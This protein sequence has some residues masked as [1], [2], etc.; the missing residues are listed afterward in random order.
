MT[1]AEQ[2]SGPREASLAFF[3]GVVVGHAS[4]L[5]KARRMVRC[6]VW[7]M[8]LATLPA[9]WA[10]LGA[11]SEGQVTPCH[12]DA[13]HINARFLRAVDRGELVLF[14]GVVD[15]SEIVVREVRYVH[16]MQSGARTLI[17][18]SDLNSPLLIP[19]DE[20]FEI[21]WLRTIMT[22]D[23]HITDTEVHAIPKIGSRAGY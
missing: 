12:A 6:C 18:I 4:S 13:H 20:R 14:G 2:M 3:A 1:G 7:T 17:V 21:G 10:G 23:G 9:A 11:P 19:G 8:T 5:K 16:N 22:V 15:R